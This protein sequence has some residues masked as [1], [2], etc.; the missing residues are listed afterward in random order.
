MTSDAELTATIAVDP[1][2]QGK[3][4]IYLEYYI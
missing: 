4:D 1:I 3:I 2:S